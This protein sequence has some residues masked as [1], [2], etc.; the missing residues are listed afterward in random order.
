MPEELRYFSH[1]R[2]MERGSREY[3]FLVIGSRT[4]QMIARV[5]CWRKGSI[6]A[7][8]ATGSRSMSDSLIACQPRMEEP[9]KPKP[10]SKDSVVSSEIG[11]VV[12]CHRPGKSM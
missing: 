2:A 6:L 5:V 3:S 12:C 4:S 1:L 10:W 7:V 11:R 8:L 9:S